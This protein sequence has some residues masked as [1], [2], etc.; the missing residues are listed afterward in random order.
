[1]HLSKDGQVV[2]VHDEELSRL[3]SFNHPTYCAKV[4]SVVVGEGYQEW[5]RL[6]K[7]QPDEQGREKKEEEN[8]SPLPLIPQEEKTPIDDPLSHLPVLRRDIALHFISEEKGATYFSSS[9]VPP[10]VRLCLLEE[11]F[12]QFPNISIHLDMKGVSLPFVTLDDDDSN[13]KGNKQTRNK[14]EGELKYPQ[15]SLVYETMRLVEKYRRERLT[16]VGS[17]VTENSRQIYQYLQ[18]KK[19]V[20]EG[21]G[22]GLDKKGVSTSQSKEQSVLLSKSRCGKSITKRESFRVFA[23][24]RQVVAVYLLYYLGILPLVPLTFDCFSIPM[25][26]QQKKR[27]FSKFL[28]AKKASVLLFLL[29]APALWCHL[30]RRGVIVLGWVVNDVC[31]VAEVAQWPVNGIMTD[32]PEMVQSY[33]RLN[34]KHS[35]HFISPPTKHTHIQ[36]IRAISEGRG[37]VEKEGK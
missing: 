5:K 12:D 1:M 32:D 25:P 7:Q 18:Q 8:I 29:R 6:R 35:M 22:R 16:I 4:G 19:E 27:T 33:L 31:E 34:P 11:V 30:Q 10:N 28:G 26:T 20:E 2:V 14:K 21:T 36:R 37:D 3:C 17:G 24:L 15:R 13:G 9:D 23:S